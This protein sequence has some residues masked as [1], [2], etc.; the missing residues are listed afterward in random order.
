MISRNIC[1]LI[2]LCILAFTNLYAA[3]ALIY[4]NSTNDLGTRFNPG[5][6]EVGDE[7]GLAGNERFLQEF[8]FEYWGTNTANPLAFSGTIQ[9]QV[10]IYLNDGLPF[11]GYLTPFTVLYDSGLFSVPTPTDRSTFIFAAGSDFPAGGLFL[12]PGPGGE[13]LTNLT[14]SI[15][16]TGMDPTDTVGLDLYSPPTVGGN[17]SDYWEFNGGSWSLQTNLVP[18]N[19]AATFSATPEPSVFALAAFGA[20]GLFGARYWRARKK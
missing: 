13:L 1:L 6:L 7:I 3:P 2:V 11:N 10:K 5:N 15:R 12:G 8:R 4:N 17:F 19:F 9:A 16:F 20:L 14:F 18:V